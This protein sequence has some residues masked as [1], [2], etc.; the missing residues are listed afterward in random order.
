MAFLIGGLESCLS[1]NVGGG[2][3]DIGSSYQQL[4]DNLYMA[5]SS[6]QD[7]LQ[8]GKDSRQGINYTILKLSRYY[9]MLIYIWLSRSLF[10]KLRS[11]GALEKL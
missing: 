6:R 4:L 2:G 1:T 11:P 3:I 10:A 7:N 9:T 5:N 8:K